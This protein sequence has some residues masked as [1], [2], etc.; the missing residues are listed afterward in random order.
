MELEDWS[1]RENRKSNNNSSK[2]AIN[3]IEGIITESDIEE[4][5]PRVKHME[6]DGGILIVWRKSS[7]NI[8]R[9]FVPSPNEVMVRGEERWPR[10]LT[11]RYDALCQIL[12]A[13]LN[14]RDDFADKLLRQLLD[15]GTIAMGRQSRQ[16]E[17]VYASSKRRKKSNLR[18][19]R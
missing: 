19:R 16:E 5:S 15:K 17:V 2:K 3:H 12:E 4:L 7:S 13:K 11:P 10:G 18:L 6:T 9:L 1:S 14:G 8:I